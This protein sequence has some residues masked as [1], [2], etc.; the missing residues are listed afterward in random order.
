MPD[1]TTIDAYGVHCLLS[2]LQP[3]FPSTQLIFRTI[4]LNSR[5][6]GVFV[7]TTV[8]TDEPIILNLKKYNE[9]KTLFD[10][11]L[12]KPLYEC[13]VFQ[14]TEA[15]DVPL[16]Y[17][18]WMLKY[19]QVP[20]E[21]TTRFDKNHSGIWGI[22]G[23]FRGASDATEYHDFYTPYI[24]MVEWI[25]KELVAM[26]RLGYIRCTERDAVRLQLNI[27]RHVDGADGV[28]AVP[29]WDAASILNGNLQS[30]V[31]ELINAVETGIT[32]E[33]FIKK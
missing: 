14:P 17:Q 22:Y 28:I 33:E 31:F 11:I 20:L 27:V 8:E 30:H 5:M 23:D 3:L 16:W 32:F 29:D 13:L 21:Y 24:T 1:R 19:L 18:S 7:F 4:Y 15:V 2:K 9:V 10:R 6:Q 26:Y 12:E 25:Q